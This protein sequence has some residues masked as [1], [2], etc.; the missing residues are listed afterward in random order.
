MTE[1]LYPVALRLHDR[2]VLVVGGGPVAARKV[3]RLL[4][5][6]ARITLVAPEAVGVLAEAAAAGALQW[7]RRPFEPG[8]IEGSVL[9][10]AATGVAAVDAEVGMAARAAQVWLN[11]A[12]SSVEGDLDLPA[13]VRRGDLTV[14]VS[15]GGAAPG[16]AADL[17]A[18]VGARLPDGV[19]DYVALLQSV[20]AGLR[21]RFPDD[22][23]RRKRAFAAALSCAEARGHAEGGHV[24]AA[25]RA[26]ERAVERVASTAPGDKADG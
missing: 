15:T 14:A 1:P 20:R 24:D 8:D 22:P 3:Q 9:V 13:L 5:C 6:G 26:L 16:F 10:F 17:A 23:F 7:R 4:D 21:A 19:G 18:E 25:R 11:A 12:D 2:P